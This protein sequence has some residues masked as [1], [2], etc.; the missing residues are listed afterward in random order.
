MTVSVPSLVFP[1]P[2]TFIGHRGLGKGTVRGHRENTLG[3]FLS[4]LDHGVDWLEVDVRRTLDDELMV[5]HNA[6]FSDGRFL[7]DMTAAEAVRRV[8]GLSELL[9]ALPPDAGVAF[10]VKSSMEDAAQTP[11]RTTAGLLA[12][13]AQRELNRRP[14]VA[15]SFDPGVLRHLRDLVPGLPL[16]LTTW[17]HYPVGHAVAAAAH[18]DVQ[19]LAIHAGSL[20]P[21]DVSPATEFRPLEQIVSRVHDSQRQL[22]VWCPTG[23]QGRLL[24]AAGADAL[25]VDDVPVLVPT[26]RNGQHDRT[27]VPPAASV[28]Q[29]HR[30]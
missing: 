26:L 29:A 11:S 28:A 18:L 4:A 8:L 1:Q 21:N 13:V 10:D 3:S 27:P 6:A 9:E 24:L 7:I 2:P 20:W 23:E 19:L 25:V 22:V 5:A 30:P 16:G 14:L 12:Q 17:L 15:L